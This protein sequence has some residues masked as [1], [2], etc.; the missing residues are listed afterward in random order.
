MTSQRNGSPLQ[1]RR[2]FR[3]VACMASTLMLGSTAIAAEPETPE[4]AH[5]I[6]MHGEATYDEGFPHFD[7]VNPQAPKG[8]TLRQ[9]VVANGY[10]SFNPLVARGVAATGITT[11]FYDTLMVSSGDEPFTAYGLIAE[12]ID[13]LLYTSPSPRDA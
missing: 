4:P 3:I 9:A 2:L 12:S 6:A 8:G 1:T 10:D 11:Y 7:Y 5:G 13:C